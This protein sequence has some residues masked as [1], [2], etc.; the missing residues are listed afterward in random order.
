MRRGPRIH[1]QEVDKVVQ[2]TVLSA[3]LK[4]LTRTCFDLPRVEEATKL[5]SATLLEL[6]PQALSL[7][8]ENYETKESTRF[9]VRRSR[10]RSQQVTRS[11][12]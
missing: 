8:S 3:T 6:D 5:L 4:A 7:L 2:R 11:A 9:E 1:T 10:L 12:R